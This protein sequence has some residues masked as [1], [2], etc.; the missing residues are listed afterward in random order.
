MQTPKNK[1]GRMPCPICNG[2]GNVTEDAEQYSFIT[3]EPET[4]VC[5]ICNGSGRIGPRKILPDGRG[6]YELVERAEGQEQK[7]LNVSKKAVI[8]PE[9]VDT[10]VGY[11]PY[12]TEESRESSRKAEGDKKKNK[13]KRGHEPYEAP[14]FMEM[15]LNPRLNKVLA[16]GK[17][18]LIV[19][20]TE[21][22]YLEVYRMIR[23]Q[24]KKQ[25]TWTQQDEELYVEALEEGYDSL[26]MDSRFRGNAQVID[27]EVSNG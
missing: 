20:E 5:L 13:R 4:N 25:G 18:F 2:T 1:D 17:E 3:R 27:K 22:Y 10:G 21:P 9:V 6:V 24:E 12:K 14:L 16:S 15:A 23:K 8:N 11:A 26:I 7:R 19:T